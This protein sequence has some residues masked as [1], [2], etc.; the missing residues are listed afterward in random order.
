[1]KILPNGRRPVTGIRKLR[2]VYQGT[3]GMG[4]GNALILHGQSDFPLHC[5]PNIVPPKFNGNETNSQIATT[6]ITAELG[7]VC[8]PYAKPIEFKPSITAAVV[9]GTME[10][11]N[12]NTLIQPGAGFG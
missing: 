2:R 12:T 5:R 10:P 1:M 11:V 8:V 4:R 3:S 6:V 9:A 7:N